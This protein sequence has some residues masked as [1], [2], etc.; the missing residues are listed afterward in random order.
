MTSIPPVPGQRF[1]IRVVRVFVITLIFVCAGT[2]IE[3]A[4]WATLSVGYAVL[5]DARSTWPT[6]ASIGGTLMWNAEWAGLTG[7]VTGIYDTSYDRVD[8]RTM[9][10]ISLVMVLAALILVLW[11]SVSALV[12]SP[13]LDP[14]LFFLF[15]GSL[16]VGLFKS[17][18]SLMCFAVSMIACWKLIDIARDRIPAAGRLLGQ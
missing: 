17:V 10:V 8:A 2:L 5:R 13:S 11:L 7:L 6:V 3:L 1:S 14:I 12:S 9:L 16:L 4:L 18:L 15:L